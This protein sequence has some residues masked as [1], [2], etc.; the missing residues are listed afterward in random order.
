MKVLIR[1]R[2]AHIYFL[3]FGGTQHALAIEPYTATP[4]A[5]AEAAK[6]FAHFYHTQERI[7]HSYPSLS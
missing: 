2:K 7:R 5:S 1:R 4:Y 3:L 6:K